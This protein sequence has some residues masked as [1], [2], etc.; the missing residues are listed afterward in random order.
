MANVYLDIAFMVPHARFGRIRRSTTFVHVER[1]S[2]FIL[3]TRVYQ[4]KF[5][6]KS[7]GPMYLDGQGDGFGVY[8]KPFQCSFNFVVLVCK[9]L[10]MKKK[11]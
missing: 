3:Y 9:L 11:N 5:Y 10:I 8:R 2:W 7:S 4:R 1:I 6:S